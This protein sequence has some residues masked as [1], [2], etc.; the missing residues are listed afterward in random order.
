MSAFIK[1]KEKNVG[2]DG[3]SLRA[4]VCLGHSGIK[5]TDYDAAGISEWQCEERFRLP[6]DACMS[7]QFRMLMYPAIIPVASAT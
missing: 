7:V 6:T 4:Q 1:R 5:R 2:Q 3:I